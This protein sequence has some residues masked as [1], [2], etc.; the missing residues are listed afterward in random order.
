MY[1]SLYFFRSSH[2]NFEDRDEN[3]T[4]AFL[5]I[6]PTVPHFPGNIQV[7]WCAYLCMCWLH[8]VH[9][10][11]TSLTQ[12]LMSVLWWAFGKVSSSS[13]WTLSVSQEP[14]FISVTR[15]SATPPEPARISHGVELPMPLHILCR[16]GHSV[17]MWT[18]W[19]THSL[20]T[21]PTK[22]HQ[23]IILINVKC[24]LQYNPLS[25][26]SVYANKLLAWTGFSEFVPQ[27]GFCLILAEVAQPQFDLEPSS[28][29]CSKSDCAHWYDKTD[30][31]LSEVALC[32]LVFKVV[33]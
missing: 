6:F 21:F 11:L 15:M 29:V 1:Y 4:L 10:A 8:A 3:P 5:T 30:I 18:N 16:K 26:G 22:H 17:Q 28:K 33:E 9:I 31:R 7:S 19:H 25:C 27:S 20:N 32:G 24:S 13:S 2:T 12:L 23:K 14:R